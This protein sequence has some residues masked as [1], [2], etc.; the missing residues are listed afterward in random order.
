MVQ[1]RNFQAS[2]VQR[3]NRQ[4]HTIAR[5]NGPGQAHVVGDPD[6]YGCRAGQMF[7]LEL[8][9]PGSG[10]KVTPIQAYWLRRWEEDAGAFTGVARD[11]ARVEELWVAWFDVELEP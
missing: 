11:M 7:H 1:E 9:V 10:S 2:V 8:K 5:V 6:V 3:L 4:P